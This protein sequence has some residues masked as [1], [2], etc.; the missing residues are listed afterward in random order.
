MRS[1]SVYDP[2]AF[3]VL[4]DPPDEA[5]LAD[6]A[7]AGSQP[8][9]TDE[10][11]GGGEDWMEAFVD[12]WNGPGAWRALPATSR[13]QF[14]RVGRKVFR[15]VMSLM[16]DRTGAAAYAGLGAPDAA[17][18]RRALAH[19]GA[20][21]HRGARRGA[22]RTARREVIPGA[23]HMGPLTHGAAVDA[24]IARHIDAIDEAA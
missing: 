3:G 2:V 18:V 20:A 7:R 10:A 22:P 21:G 12:Y 9:F 14:L 19:R 16:H 4:R 1:L 15:E 17:A 5:G 13:E 6:L 24:L 8:V 23:G 11:R